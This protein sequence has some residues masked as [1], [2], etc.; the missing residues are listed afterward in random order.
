[1]KNSYLKC[2]LLS[3]FVCAVFCVPTVKLQASTII[4]SDITDDTVWSVANS[5]YVISKL[6]EVKSGAKLVIEPGVTVTFDKL[7]EIGVLGSVE[8]VG[9]DDN[10]II[11]T[12][13]VATD[14]STAID[15]FA[16][17]FVFKANSKGIFSHV[18]LHHSTV[19]ITA[20]KADITVQHSHF[21]HNTRSLIVTGGTF[22]LRDTV[23]KDNFVPLVVSFATVFMHSGN[24]I[25]GSQYNSVHLSGTVTRDIV[26]HGDDTSYF[27]TQAFTVPVGYTFT[28]GAGAVVDIANTKNPIQ[29]LG[30]T[31]VAQGT[32]D[33]RIKFTGPSIF[34]TDKAK[35]SLSY[36]DY[37][38]GRSTI[39]YFINASKG[40]TVAVD[41]VQIDN[42]DPRSVFLI[43]SNSTIEIENSSIQNFN[44]GLRLY[45]EAK[46]TVKNTIFD[47]GKLGVA[48]TDGST[49][50]F[51]RAVVTNCTLQGI[52]GFRQ[53]STIDS[54]LVLRHSEIFGNGI[55]VDLVYT[56]V[57]ATN[58]SIH[59]NGTGVKN[60]G[61]TPL[62]F[63]TNWWGDA[64]GPH[65]AVTNPEG[66][67][68]AVS[69]GVEFDPWL[70]RD[71]I[72][73]KKTPVLIVPGV[74]ATE[75]HK[76]TE[77]GLEKLW[78]D[79]VRN[80]T[81]IGD[82]FMDPLQF[83]D[84]LA[85]M[86]DTLILGN[87]IREETA[88]IVGREV[89]FL[90]YTEGLI[91]ELKQQ[92]YVYD[93]DLFVFPYDWRYGVSSAIIGQLKQK[94]TDIMNTTGSDEVD[95]IAHSNGG[96]I[97]KKYA[98]EYPDD[99]HINKAVFVGVPNLGAPSAL[100]NLLQGSN[101]G[102]MFLSEKEIRKLV[103]N[104]P[105]AYML[106]P[107]S[108]Y[109]Q[110]KGSYVKVIER[111]FFDTVDS[112]ELSHAEVKDFLLDEHDL[113]ARAFAQGEDL[114]TDAF[115]TF[116]LRSVDIKPYTI[117]GCRAGTFG[118]I[119]EVRNVNF[120]GSPSVSYRA[121]EETP[122][123]GTVPLESADALPTDSDHKYYALKSNHMNMLS[124]D[125]TRQAVVNIISGSLLLT[126]DKKGADV[127]TQDI[128]ECQLNGRLI[129]VYSPLLIDVLDGE[130]NR[131]RFSAS[132]KS[133]ENTIPN[134][135][136]VVM[137]DRKFVYLPAGM[138][139]TYTITLRG[140]AEGVFTLTDAVIVNNDV[141][142]TSVFENIAVTD[143]LTGEMQLG[144]QP[145]LILSSHDEVLHPSFVLD[146]T[147]S[148][149]FD[150]D[151][152]EE[153]PP[154]ETDTIDDTETEE[155][156]TVDESTPETG[157]V[158]D[159]DVQESTASGGGIVIFPSVVEQVATALSLPP[160]EEKQE[161][162]IVAPLPESAVP[163]PTAETEKTVEH[164]D[165]VPTAVSPEVPS[166]PQSENP[167]QD[168]LS[169]NVQTSGSSIDPILVWAGAVLLAGTLVIG[170]R[171]MKR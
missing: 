138:G 17:G 22:D 163:M 142:Q 27:F 54:N 9:A 109:Y 93:Q 113:N 84:D 115:D 86:D 14:D 64:S 120:L 108:Q 76:P 151:H 137:G 23:F 168:M 107:S 167:V 25:T 102:N 90:N 13:S 127:V 3:L 68:D 165:E 11:F 59:G 131:A 43:G 10:K 87:V 154:E 44:E 45:D 153:E 30:G 101:F 69:E 57:S 26:L 58:N 171:Y 92:A 118:K 156:E 111:N 46:G 40:T 159:D 63:K 98:M 103:R 51:D 24:Q 18:A 49:I 129:S 145:T 112:K 65:N 89:N 80:F 106:L 88:E 67:G 158:S 81:D 82:Q 126:E 73:D 143:D 157:E 15:D 5:P 37:L 122:G 130:G 4:T 166:T 6:V 71:P 66:G 128:G 100:K 77:N 105:M 121:P 116:D 31:F 36:F 75:M 97:V 161:E 125:G 35:V 72:N 53:S 150:P 62:D 83:N 110:Q 149:A 133:I 1:M 41:D 135:D 123:D 104:L 160:L 19:G 91:E 119:V 74:M 164:Q 28:I 16:R 99:N 48:L 144:A 136:Y 147:E 146:A 134:A 170:K 139:E 96:L 169:A 55:G 60:S 70:I 34:A 85:P 29:V 141:V 20:D 2:L 38:G 162:E 39:S 56:N 42:V 47:K 114:H 50:E 61:Q 32:N 79:L 140:T 95:I 148:E 52:K 12:S 117:S 7:G 8:A 132:D 155:D 152:V 94:I 21:T 124:E 78:L 33:R